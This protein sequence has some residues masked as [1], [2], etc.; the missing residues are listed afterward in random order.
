MQH[1][2]SALGALT[3]SGMQLANADDDTLNNRTAAVTKRERRDKN[4]ILWG[5]FGIVKPTSGHGPRRG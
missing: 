5:A 1:A 3:S 4:L 2:I